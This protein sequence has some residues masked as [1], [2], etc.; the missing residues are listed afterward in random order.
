MSA[1]A[2]AQTNGA[3]ALEKLSTFFNNVNPTALFERVSLTS[4]GLP[5][6]HLQLPPH[7]PPTQSFN[8]DYIK[9]AAEALMTFKLTPLENNDLAN[10]M[11]DPQNETRI[12]FFLKFDVPSHDLWIKNTLA[13]IKAKKDCDMERVNM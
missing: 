11:S 8:N 4:L 3:N 1:T 5:Q 13:E 7:I 6:T 10:Y 12:R 9:Q 2:Q